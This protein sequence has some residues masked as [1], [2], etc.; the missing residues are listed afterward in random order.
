VPLFKGTLTTDVMVDNEWGPL[1]HLHVECQ[2][3][4]RAQVEG[5]FEVI[6]Q[7]L[8]SHSIYKGQ[9]IDGR[10]NP[11]FVDL[12]GVRSEQVIFSDEVQVQLEANVWALLR[13]SQTMRE[14]GIPLKRAVL[15]EGPY[16]TGKTLAAFLTAQVAVENGWSFIY[17]RAGKD[18]LGE[19]FATAR[20]YQPAVVFFEDVDVAT[21]TDATRN[22]PSIERLL[23]MFDGITAKGTEI[24]AVLTTNH[25]ERIHK[26]MIRPGRLDSLIHI[27]AL[28]N[29]GIERMIKAVV[30]AD[31]LGE[32][33]YDEVA[34]EMGAGPD[35]TDE[36]RQEHG[37]LPAFVKEAIDRAQRYAISR[38]NGQPDVLFTGDFVQ[39]AA[40]LRPQLDLMSQAKDAR[41]V[42]PLDQALGQVVEEEVRDTLKTM[43]LNTGSFVFEDREDNLE[44]RR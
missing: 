1:F 11:E 9:A 18:D 5:L 37:F 16:G 23:D 34:T 33:D 27:G 4:Y 2:R 36:Q 22:S 3:K 24:M 15:L 31:L 10:T 26:G 38:N 20:L 17:C 41:E 42:N 12:R 13:Y 29:H 6:E 40:G 19:A 14:T 28:D 43:R 7:E 35:T 25:P 44:L 30:P 39:A 8:R 32:V 21:T